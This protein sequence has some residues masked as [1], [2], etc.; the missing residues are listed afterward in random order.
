V[1]VKAEQEPDSSIAELQAASIAAL[2]DPDS[3]A[4]KDSDADMMATR[5]TVTSAQTVSSTTV[6]V[7]ET[8]INKETVAQTTSTTRQNEHNL[9]GMGAGQ[10]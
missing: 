3:P 10:G 8:G 7:D 5:T 6:S 1:Q 2:S 9:P 4:G